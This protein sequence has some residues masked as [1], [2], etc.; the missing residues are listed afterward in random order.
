MVEAAR[1]NADKPRLSEL[2]HFGVAI[3]RLVE[4]MEKGRAKYPDEAPG[5]PNFT[6][7]GKPD[8]EYIDCILRHARA[9][10]QGETHD[11]EGFRHDAA[12]A[13]NA[14]V[15]SGINHPDRGR[16]FA[17]GD[18]VCVIDDDEVG[19]I[20]EVLNDGA[21]VCVTYISDDDAPSFSCIFVAEEVQYLGR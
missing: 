6:L 18:R 14:L 16:P 10:K 13:W 12:I 11:A 20:T 8:D 15:L 9:I 4:H 3:D 5:V 2:F 19:T 17:V 21:S 7:G 1:D